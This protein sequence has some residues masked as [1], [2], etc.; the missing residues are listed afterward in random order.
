ME[1]MNNAFTYKLI[2]KKCC[3][4]LQKLLDKYAADGYI[5]CHDDLT[6]SEFVFND[7]ISF[8]ML[9]VVCA[10]YSIDQDLIKRYG[11][12][13]MEMFDFSLREDV[14]KG[15]SE[16]Y[17]KKVHENGMVYISQGFVLLNNFD[18]LTQA[19]D[20]EFFKNLQIENIGA[21]TSYYI[22]LL[23]AVKNVVNEEFKD[24]VDS[25]GNDKI[26]NFKE[27][28]TNFIDESVAE[29]QKEQVQY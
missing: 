1:D 24:Y 20:G 12:S 17:I 5:K 25:L 7:L 15:F 19:N 29:M 16:Q 26:N 2:V 21:L 8:L 14:F 4:T 18:N 13:N 28:I 3:E 6:P 22:S 27:L 23:N 9:P 10:T 11:N